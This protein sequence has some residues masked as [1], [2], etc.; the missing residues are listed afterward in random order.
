MK[1]F[2]LPS[3][4]LEQAKQKQ[5]QLIDAITREFDG[6][7]FLSMGDLGVIPG[8]NKPVYADKVERV[9]ADFFHAERTLLVTGSGTGAIR[10][11]LQAMV[12]AGDAIFVHSAPIYPTTEVTF[13]SMGLKPVSVDFND[14]DALQK[15][16]ADHPEIH[17]ALIQYT[18]QAIEDSY[19]MQDVIESIQSVRNVSILTDDNYAVMKVPYIGTELGADISAFSCFKLQGPEGVGLVVGKAKWIDRIEKMNYSGGS[20][21]Q[22]W[23]AMEVLRGMTYAPVTLAI[24]A[25][26]NEEVVSRLRSGEIPEICDAFL[27]NAQSKVLLVKFRENIAKA[28]LEEAQKLGGLPNP[29]G[30][31]SKYELVPMF[32]RVSGTFRKTDPTLEER[33]IRVNPNRGGTE[34]IIRILK[35]SIRKAKECF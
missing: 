1:T 8:L 27:A 2:P 26:V 4:T 7:D 21:V 13:Q 30:A 3:L 33:M 16:V 10:W 20:K 17:C 18:R 5:F 11:G 9:L 28:V 32:Y 23:Q 15:A 29:V 31:E 14:L 35:E 34:T 12:R 24:Q 22:G 6:K 25:Q 19:A